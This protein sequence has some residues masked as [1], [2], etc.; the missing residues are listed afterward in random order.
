MNLKELI[1]N[2]AEEITEI[3]NTLPSEAS[4]TIIADARKNLALLASKLHR[5]IGGLPDTKKR[6]FERWQNGDSMAYAGYSV[7]PKRDFG[8]HMPPGVTHGWV[9]VKDGCNALPGATWASTMAE[10]SQLIDVLLAVDE[11]TDK[12]QRFWHL[13]SAIQGPKD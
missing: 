7:V 10:A 8:A 11:N 4:W 12:Q 5:E 2:A 9:V 3:A 13:L 6:D 1:K